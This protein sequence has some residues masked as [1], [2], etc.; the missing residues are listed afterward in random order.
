MNQKKTNLSH[1]A[2]FRLGR[3]QSLFGRYGLPAP[4]L[5]WED[6]EKYKAF[7]RLQTKISTNRVVCVDNRA[8][9][10]LVRWHEENPASSFDRTRTAGDQHLR[11][12]VVVVG[13]RKVKPCRTF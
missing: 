8:I 13:Y 5:R 4:I 9:R 2:L 10:L 12:L 11:H 3:I 1:H 7:G 6:L